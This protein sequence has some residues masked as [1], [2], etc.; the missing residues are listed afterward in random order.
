MERAQEVY[1]KAREY[2]DY[3]AKN[4]SKLIKIK[5]LSGQEKEVVAAVKQMMEEANFDEVKI[6]GLGNVIGRIGSG[7]KIIALDGH[8]DTVDMGNLDDWEF[9][10]LGGEIQFGYVQGR[11]A[12]DQTG[13]PAAFITAGRIL[14]EI[15][16]DN[17]VTIYFTATVMEEDCDGLCWKYIVEEDKIKPECVVV[18]EPTNL[19][20][21][22]GQRG[23]MEIEVSFHGLSAHGSA[24]ERGKNAIYMASRVALEIEKLNERLASD[25]FLGKGSVTISEFVSSSPSLC[26]VSDFAKIHLDRRL[27]WGEDK[28][29]ALNEVRE[30]V[31]NENANVELLNYSEKAY[32]GLQY[33]MEKYYP[34][35]KIEED[36]QV[37]QTGV[38][39]FEELFKEKPAIDKWTFST[40]GVTINGLYKI[41]VI[42]F[43]PGKEEMAHA[44]NEKVSID[45]L[46]KASAFYANFCSIY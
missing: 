14:K 2:S 19:N 30:I 25:P 35:W 8:I 4:L 42:G 16:L 11:G 26:A 23:R 40:N 28:E 44:P 12:S 15:G 7:K 5:S 39:A 1:K 45:H 22:R 43:G 18:T 3:T 31:R 36:H 9:D 32:T 29:L 33:G 10:P 24:P 41:P 46:I 20:I 17:D 27:T 37:I 21:Y 34:T 38:K 6:D 13:G